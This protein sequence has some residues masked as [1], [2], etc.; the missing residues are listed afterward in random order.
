[1]KKWS[2]SDYNLVLLVDSMAM[3]RH[4]T[5]DFAIAYVQLLVE[6]CECLETVHLGHIDTLSSP[7]RRA[8]CC[9]TGMQHFLDFPEQ[10]ISTL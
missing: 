1:M 8:V 3:D 5:M 9:G 4:I 10:L 7:A 2:D 6:L